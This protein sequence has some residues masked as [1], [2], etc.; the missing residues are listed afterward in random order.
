MR[1]IGIDPGQS[2]GIAVLDE[3]GYVIDAFKMPTS[4]RLLL[5]AVSGILEDEH[6][7]E[8]VLEFVRSSPVMGQRAA[9]TFGWGL[10]GLEMALEAYCIPYSVVVPRKWQAGLGIG[11]TGGDKNI[12]KA[13]AVALFPGVTVTHAIADALLI[14]EFARRHKLGLIEHKPT[15]RG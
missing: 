9:F 8:A 13:K 5:D 14:T 6:E 3:Q 10:G 11:K 7:T 1:F 12:T 15:R 2:G 4:N